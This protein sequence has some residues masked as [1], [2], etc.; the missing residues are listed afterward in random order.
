MISLID[1]EDHP[2]ALG[3]AVFWP[4]LL[5]RRLNLYVGGSHLVNDDFSL[6]SLFGGAGVGDVASLM[7]E[8]AFSDK[9][10]IR[11]TA[12]LSVDLAYQGLGA[13][14]LTARGETGTSTLLRDGTANVELE[15]KQAV[16]GAH[17][18]LTPQVVLRPEYRLMDTETFRSG[19]YAAQL[20][21][22]V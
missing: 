12:S 1:D 7:V 16:L 8:Y 19:R 15:T 5:E 17:V 22:Y 9:E 20:H 2:T 4:R 13:I 3:R 21:V 14:V 11:E 18:F 10:G 6:T